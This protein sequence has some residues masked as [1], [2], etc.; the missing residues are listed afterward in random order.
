VGGEVGEGDGVG[1]EVSEGLEVGV[2]VVEGRAVGVGVGVAEGEGVGVGDPPSGSS[3]LPLSRSVCDIAYTTRDNSK[4][5]HTNRR[6]SSFLPI[7]HSMY[8]AHLI[9][10]SPNKKLS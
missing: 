3:E 1:L 8:N 2:G 7:F 10:V 4:Q 9:S 5:A 6:I